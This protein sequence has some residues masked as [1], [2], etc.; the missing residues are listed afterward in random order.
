M[1]SNLLTELAERPARQRPTQHQMNQ[2]LDTLVNTTDE[3]L[4]RLKRTE[5]ALLVSRGL[6]F[7]N[8]ID[9][10]RI[11]K[12]RDARKQLLIDTIN[13]ATRERK[14]LQQLTGELTNVDLDSGVEPELTGDGIEF[15]LFVS[16]WIGRLDRYIVGLYD[17]DAGIYREH[18]KDLDRIALAVLAFLTKPRKQKTMYGNSSAVQ[19][20][21][22]HHILN[23]RNKIRR[24]LEKYISNLPPSTPSERKDKWIET[25]NILFE[26]NPN[27]KH[28]GLIY[29]LTAE[30]SKD[31]RRNTVETFEGRATSINEVRMDSLLE[32]AKK[33]LEDCNPERTEDWREVMLAL[34]LVTGRRSVEVFCTGMF[35]PVNDSMVTIKGKSY[36]VPATHLIRFTGQCKTRGVVA[37][38]YVENPSYV[39]PVLVPAVLVL[40]GFQLILNKRKQAF[41]IDVIP[42]G[43]EGYEVR[44]RFNRNFQGEL[45]P[46]TQRWR[47]LLGNIPDTTKFTTHKLRSLYANTV[48]LW[49]D[50]N[51]QTQDIR[52]LADLLGDGRGG[53]RPSSGENYQIGFNI[54]QDS[55]THL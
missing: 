29:E 6:G 54:S 17:R 47:K 37:Q 5:L 28:Y 8:V 16:D 23:T 24:T 48:Q 35:E 50:P 45:T 14:A 26:N 32:H 27:R 1:L 15:D 52:F 30:F 19:M 36:D 38:Y 34:C 31:R 44:Q 53:G 46:V 25:Y 41:G 18:T 40:R 49:L 20:W 12:S 2:V 42:T 43:D 3:T 21:S 7:P 10:D 33:I 22:S 51:Q 4:I 9:N 39:I 13:T 55:M 11:F